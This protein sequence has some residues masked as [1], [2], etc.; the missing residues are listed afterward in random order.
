MA[1]PS[2]NEYMRQYYENNPDKLELQRQ[3]CREYAKTHREQRRIRQNR[4]YYKDVEATRARDKIYKSSRLEFGRLCRALK[5]F[6]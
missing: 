5:A 4:H 6:K 2:R 3:R 1:T